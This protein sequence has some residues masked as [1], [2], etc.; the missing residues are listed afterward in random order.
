MSTH[1]TLPWEI[2]I[3]LAIVLWGTVMV[4]WIRENRNRRK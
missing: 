4:L 3:P 2:F 1:E